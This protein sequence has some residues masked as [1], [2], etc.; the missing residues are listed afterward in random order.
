MK[1]KYINGAR[2]NSCSC[3]SWFEHWKKYSGEPLSI[4]CAVLDCIQKPEVGSH[5][6]KEDT[7]DSGSYIVPLCRAHNDRYWSS[8]YITEAVT[9]VSANVDRTCGK[10]G[11]QAAGGTEN[12]NSAIEANQAVE[13]K[14][15]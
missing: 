15:P 10:T 5:V 13:G 6:Q 9:L 1:V 3:G 4:F 8:Y 11:S 14:R 7:D 12:G 2:A